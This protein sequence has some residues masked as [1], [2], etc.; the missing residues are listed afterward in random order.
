MSNDDEAAI[1]TDP[2]SIDSDSDTVPDL[3]EVGP[4]RA[5]PR[6]TDGDGAIDAVDSDDDDDGLATRDERS[7]ATAAGSADPD[8]DGR[9]AWRDTD[10]DGDGVD[11]GIDD[12]L[13]DADG[14]GRLDFLDNDSSSSQPPAETEPPAQDPGCFGS[15][16][17]AQPSQAPM[18]ALAA[19]VALGR[20]WRR[21]RRGLDA[22]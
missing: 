11:D 21:R 15:A 4:D 18:V 20:A 5:A 6:D 3:E 22:A 2:V 8:G 10:S 7:A 16:T 14:D 17:L 12:G 9:P 1:G 13:G 19:L